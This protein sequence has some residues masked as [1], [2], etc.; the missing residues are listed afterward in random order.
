LIFFKNRL[1]VDGNQHGGYS[2]KFRVVVQTRTT[3]FE[4]II[5]AVDAVRARLIAQQQYPK[6]VIGGC[7]QM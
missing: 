5:E 7:Y 6:A 1:S 4:T 3:V 2:M